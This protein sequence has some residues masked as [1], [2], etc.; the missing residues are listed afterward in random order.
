MSGAGSLRT[1]EGRS[2]QTEFFPVYDPIEYS[3]ICDG[4]KTHVRSIKRVILKHSDSRFP[5]LA[6]CVLDDSFTPLIITSVTRELLMDMS[7]YDV[8]C[9]GYSDLTSFKKDWCRKEGVSL[10]SPHERV[11]RYEFKLYKED[12]LD[13]D[14]VYALQ[15]LASKLY[16]QDLR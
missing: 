3:M 5:R 1:W 2:A 6:M 12:V 4:I 13:D 9:E 14:T 10:F 16:P 11:F 15:K 8:S 7:D